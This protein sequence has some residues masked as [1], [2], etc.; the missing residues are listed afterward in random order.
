M[1]HD[2]IKQFMQILVGF[3]HGHGEHVLNKVQANGKVKGDARTVPT[4]ATFE[5]YSEHLLGTGTSLGLIPLLEDNTCFFGAID[6]DIQGEVKLNETIEELERRVREKEL[7]LV[8]CRSKSGGAHLY[9]FMSKPCSATLMQSKLTEFSIALGYGGCEVFPKQTLRVSEKDLGNWINIAMY[10]ALSAEGTTRFA[11]R[12]GEHIQALDDFVRYAKSMQLT[13]RLLETATPKLSDLFAD[14]PPCLQQIASNGL[15]EG[16]RNVTLTNVVIY[17]KKK[18]P[19]EWQDKLQEFNFEHVHP[20]LPAAELSQIRKNQQRKTYYYQ[21]KQP[22]LCNHC[23][24]KECLKREF[25]VVGGNDGGGNDENILFR[26]DGLVIHQQGTSIQYMTLNVLGHT[27]TMDPRAIRSPE[28]VAF[29]FLEQAHIVLMPFKKV[30]WLNKLAE[31]M[32]TATI[33]QL[34]D[35]ACESGQFYSLMDVFLS[36]RPTHSKNELLKGNVYTENG[37][38]YFR[39]RDLLTFLMQRRFDSK[40]AQVWKWVRGMDGNSDTMRIDGKNYRV[41]Y[42]PEPERSNGG[43]FPLPPP[44]ATEI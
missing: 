32:L 22:P 41:W 44:L 12:N 31:L 43:E 39:S 4:G 27:I 6:I 36:Q 25:G 20:P 29:A 30:D 26:A 23:D 17:L 13:P 5:H 3:E 21:C 2:L 42:V 38:C 9:A 18:Y 8:V 34:P 1:S 37:H 11:I 10:G 28:E 7:P 15:T 14:G 35:D 19:E 40:P 33:Q 24:K 16:G